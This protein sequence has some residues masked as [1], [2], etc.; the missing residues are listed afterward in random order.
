MI[1]CRICN[2]EFVQITLRHVAKHDLTL[3]LYRAQF[4]DAPLQD[5][6]MIMRGERNPFFGRKHTEELKRWQSEHFTGK[7]QDPSVGARIAAKWRDPNGVYR[8]L[9][10]SDSYR[11]RVSAAVKA[12]WDSPASAEHRRINQQ[13]MAVNH[14][15]IHASTKLVYS[16]AEYRRKR[17][18][19][20]RRH[21]A[22]LSR[23]ARSARVHRQLDSMMITGTAR[24]HGERILFDVLKELYPNA[25]H[26]V[27][28]HP[29]ITG[30]KRFW[31]VDIYVPELDTYV[32]FDGTYWHGLDRPIEIIRES[33]SAC[34]TTIY[35]KWS[36]D[37]EQDA[38]FSANGKRLIRVTDDEFKHDPRSCVERIVNV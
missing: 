7:K 22:S 11:A 26:N 4:P 12:H 20:T 9:M 13:S 14:A 27:W 10:A 23:T 19:Q 33:R 28:L 16:T 31:N 8:K 3:A 32:Q 15:K 35:K 2:K 18:D 24:S 17:S 25:K 5:E 1:A 38:W 29:N 30:A 37:R 34:D 6:S 21:W 36:T